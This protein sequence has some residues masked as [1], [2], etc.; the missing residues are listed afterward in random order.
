VFL[1][2]LQD[3]RDDDVIRARGAR[4]ARRARRRERLGAGRVRGGRHSDQAGR[5]A[6]QRGVARRR[7]H[8][9]RVGV[10]SGRGGRAQQQ[11]GHR[12]HARACGAVPAKGVL[13]WL[14]PGSTGA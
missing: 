2:R 14:H 3:V 13:R 8:R 6:V 9:E 11:R 10:N 4:R 1:P 12:Q 5:D 7:A